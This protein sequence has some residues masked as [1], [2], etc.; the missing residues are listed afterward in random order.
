ME[1]L[2]GAL[3]TAVLPVRTPAGSTVDLDRVT[4]AIALTRVLI[5]R[6]PFEAKPVLLA[7]EEAAELAT[8]GRGVGACTRR[9]G[10]SRRVSGRGAGENSD[11][12]A[13]S[14]LVSLLKLAGAAKQS[15][16]LPLPV[17]VT[18]SPPRSAGLKRGGE[19]GEG[20]VGVGDDEESPAKDRDGWQ[21]DSSAASVTAGLLLDAFVRSPTAARRSIREAMQQG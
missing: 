21:A 14:P 13:A 10:K 20:A 17:P 2:H 8:A 6:V 18:V 9:S 15:R 19:L 5:Q 16:L 7:V 1:W 4:S 3:A 11:G 12:D